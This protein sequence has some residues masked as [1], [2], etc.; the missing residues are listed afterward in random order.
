[1]QIDNHSHLLLT[2]AMY[3]CVCKAVTDSRIRTAVKG[4]ACSLRE[5]TRDLGVG[6]GC[7]KCVPTAQQVLAEELMKGHMPLLSA[8]ENRTQNQL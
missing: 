6:T 5:L 8:H 1:M 2:T 4:G 3:I 7:G